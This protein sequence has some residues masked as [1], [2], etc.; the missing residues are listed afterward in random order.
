MIKFWEKTQIAVLFP[1]SADVHTIWCKLMYCFNT[2]TI[3]CSEYVAQ[4][5]E[6]VHPTNHAEC[7]STLQTF[8]RNAENKSTKNTKS[9]LNTLSTQHRLYTTCQYITQNMNWCHFSV[10]SSF[11]THVIPTKIINS[12]SDLA[13]YQPS[14]GQI[15]WIYANANIRV[16]TCLLLYLSTRT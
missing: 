1:K 13:P 6:F 7:I 10:I 12:P 15:V 5:A 8:R 11:F 14:F 9:S 3:C 2:P 4:M 16:R